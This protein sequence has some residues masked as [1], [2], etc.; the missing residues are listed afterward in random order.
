MVEVIS[1]LQDLA[2]LVPSVVVGGGFLL[3]VV[4]VI[5]HEMAPKHS[6]DYEEQAPSEDVLETNVT[7]EANHDI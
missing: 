3:G 2:T 7:S 4:M 6:E 1:M 5:R